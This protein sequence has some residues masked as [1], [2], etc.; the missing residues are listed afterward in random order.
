[1]GIAISTTLMVPPT[2]ATAP[3]SDQNIS[4]LPWLAL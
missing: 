4:Q 3:F 1:M 2:T